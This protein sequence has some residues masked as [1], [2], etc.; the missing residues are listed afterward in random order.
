MTRFRE[1]F[2]DL[3]RRIRPYRHVPARAAIASGYREYEDTSVL[4]VTTGPYGV[5]SVKEP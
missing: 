1:T 3:V 5:S 4:R 2:P